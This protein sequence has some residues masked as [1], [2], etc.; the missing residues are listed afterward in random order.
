MTHKK[1]DLGN[2]SLTRTNTL[3]LAFENHGDQCLKFHFLLFLNIYERTAMGDTSKIIQQ[4]IRKPD[5]C[6][7]KTGRGSARARIEIN[8]GFAEAVGDL[9]NGG[10]SSE[11]RFELQSGVTTIVSTREA[12]AALNENE[13]LSLGTF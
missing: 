4:N 11:V 1:N 3:Q 5:Y 9:R 10:D 2:N 8:T 7:F 13:E 6:Y 12:F